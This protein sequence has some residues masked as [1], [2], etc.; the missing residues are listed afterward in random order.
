[1]DS[2]PVS[3]ARHGPLAVAWGWCVAT[4]NDPSRIA[5]LYLPVL[6]FLPLTLGSVSTFFFF[7]ACIYIGLLFF[8]GRVGW[9]WPP[10]T[11]FGCIASLVFFASTVLSPL[12]FPNKLAGWMD[13][14]TAF[15]Y[16]ALVLIV[17]TL[18]QTPKIDVFDLFLNGLRLACIVAFGYAVIEV[19]VLGHPRATAGMANAIP[20][21]DTAVLSGSLSMVGFQRLS[22]RMRWLAATAFVC[23]IG[24]A[25][26]SQTRGALLAVPLV[27][28]VLVL[29]LW[30]LIRARLWQALAAALIAA[31][32]L[33]ALASIM[34]LPER[35]DEVRQALRS[36]T[37]G[38]E[39]DVSTAHRVYLWTYGTAAFRDAPV[40][41]Y[42][43]QNAVSEVRARAA[44]DGIALPPYRHLHNEFLT[45]AVGRGLAG[46]A[47]MLLLL[48]APIVIAI[49]SAQDDRLRDRRAFAVLLSGCYALFGLTNLLFSHDQTNTVFASCYVV[50]LA[51]SHQSRVG[52][53]RFSRP[54][55]GIPTTARDFHPAR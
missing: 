46:L 50:L 49:K 25:M 6:A 54:F 16:A 4:Y 52:L 44:R 38:Q 40:L 23:G 53:T 10:T 18:V 13:V 15:H 32:A 17:G 27:G 35:L 55:L 9:V 42:G 3:A 2:L 12:L 34:R 11:A 22:T 30:P 43:S 37:L 8:T 47:A 29:H 19:F 26:L 5:W 48:A 39:H 31:V 24:A 21:G 51:A 20:F 33:G 41:G 45:V 1:M 28:L 7:G 36:E 14:G